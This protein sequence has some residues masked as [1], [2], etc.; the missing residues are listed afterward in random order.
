M[1]DALLAVHLSPGVLSTP[2]WVGGY[3]GMVLLL[4]PAVWR[5]REA[6]VPRIGVLSAAFFVASSVH[7]KLVVVPASVHLILNGL[8][9]VVLGRR[10][11]LAVVV[12]L[13][14][15]AL[16]I[17]HGG[18]DTL[19]VNACIVG[20]PAVLAGWLYRPL[21]RA[22][23]PAFWAGVVLGGGAVAAAAG[24]NFLVLLAGGKDDWGTLARV[25][26]LFHL[27]VVAVEGLMLGVIVSY[28]ERV[29]PE[30]LRTPHAHPRPWVGTQPGG[31]TSSNGTSH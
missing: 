22:G 15:Q 3:A 5:L 2:W 21:R 26:L 19:G 25:V 17:G 27:P 12:G 7:I 1:P 4:L 10:A 16:L 14:L 24:L 30:M 29:K 18:L 23:V 31:N 13:V 20:L 28:L 8:V 6:E 9:G 11:M